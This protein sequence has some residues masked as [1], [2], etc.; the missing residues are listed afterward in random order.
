MYRSNDDSRGY[1]AEPIKNISGILNV[2]GLGVIELN[3]LV[4]IKVFINFVYYIL[5]N[6][7]IST[8]TII[9]IIEHIHMI[10]IVAVAS[11]SFIAKLIV[12]ASLFNTSIH[13][14]VIFRSN[15][16]LFL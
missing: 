16:V 10:K 2:L 7:L 4:E 15:K 8:S 1:I 9:P 12:S 5:L 6:I 3:N 14:D 13:F 11:A